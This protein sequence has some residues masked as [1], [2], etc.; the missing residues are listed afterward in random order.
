MCRCD[1]KVRV[2]GADVSRFGADQR[3]VNGLGH[4]R[5]LERFVCGTR[6]IGESLPFVFIRL[7]DAPELLTL[8]VGEVEP[9]A[10]HAEHAKRAFQPGSKETARTGAVWWAHA[11]LTKRSWVAVR[12]LNRCPYACADAERNQSRAARQRDA[13]RNCRHVGSSISS[14]LT[15]GL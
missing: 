11:R 8:R 7:C 14:D 9:R 10:E 5:L 13:L 6:A 2:H 3:L 4:H 12:I 1:R 15:G